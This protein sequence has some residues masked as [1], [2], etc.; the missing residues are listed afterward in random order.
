M[1]AAQQREAG[2][3]CDPSTVE[4]A[5]DHTPLAHRLVAVASD[6]AAAAVAHADG[7]AAAL[8]DQQRVALQHEALLVRELQQVGIT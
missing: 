5:A 7:L 2:K 1:A 8:S 4:S 6:K 3:H